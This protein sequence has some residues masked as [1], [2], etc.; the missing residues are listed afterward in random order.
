MKRKFFRKSCILMGIFC[1]VIFAFIFVGDYN[2]PESI[3]FYDNT[4]ETEY[5]NIYRVSLKNNA[6]TVSSSNNNSQCEK[7][8]ISLLGII[9]IGEI[10]A[11]VTERKY[12]NIGG[13]LIGIRMY[14]QGLMVVG[15]DDAGGDSPAKKCGIQTGDRIIKINDVAVKSVA[16]FT[17]VIDDSNGNSVNITVERNSK[18]MYFTLTPE[19]VEA[20][21]KYKCGLWLRD[22]SAGIGTLTFTDP[23]TSMFGALG[24]AIFDNDTDSVINLATGDILSAKVNG[25]TM[26]Q[27]GKTGSISGS[28]VGESLGDLQENNQY[29]VYGTYSD[30]SLI[31]GKLYPVAS[32]TEIEIGE[33]Q[34]ISTVTAEVCETYDIEIE[35][36]I[37]NDKKSVRSLVIKI[38]DEELLELTGGIIQGMSGSPII[39]NGMFVGA[40]THVFLNDPQRGYGIFAETMVSESD[41]IFSDE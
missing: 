29:G 16:E 24:H 1:L 20:E 33:A 13:S 2:K 4:T 35:K 23:E 10:D 3:V 15:T 17:S 38:T 27:K 8:E 41:R 37:Y 9:P 21:N 12:V 19:F 34:I 26:G 5:M 28:F 32:Q 22:S 18:T 11:Q 7:A 39:Q 31:S 25:C 40:V 30:A 36:I 6:K 14:S